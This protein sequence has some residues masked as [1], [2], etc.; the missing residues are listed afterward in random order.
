MRRLL[1]LACRAFPREHRARR[2]DE[3][4]DTALLAADDSAW[5]TTREAVSLVVAGMGERLRAESDRSLRDGVAV[6]AGVLAVFNLALALAGIAACISTPEKRLYYLFGFG[7]GGSVSGNGPYTLDWW[8]IAFAVAAVG[9]ALGL[10]RGSRRLALGAAIANLGLVAYDAIFLAGFLQGHLKIFTFE[11]TPDA[12]PG[13]RQWLAGAVLLAL[14]TAVAPL[15]R[16]P[17]GRLPLALVAVGL[18]VVLSRREVASSSSCAGRS[19]RFSCSPSR[20]VR[21]RLGLRRWPP[22]PHSSRPRAHSST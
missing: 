9:V 21:S 10:M 6:L 19:P 8:L 4:V 12:F 22:A 14:A 15:R 11:Q 5:R 3:V 18:L 13:G 7:W 2:S 20:S 17:L 1:L 16:L